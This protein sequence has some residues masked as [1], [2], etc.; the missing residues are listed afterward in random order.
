MF[1]KLWAFD[2]S[3]ARDDVSL[4]APNDFLFGRYI[5]DLN[6]APFDPLV[7]GV[8]SIPVP[9]A[10]PPRPRSSAPSSSGC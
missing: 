2:P 7:D 9:R 5:A 1:D 6:T 4:D 3:S 8:C 10:T